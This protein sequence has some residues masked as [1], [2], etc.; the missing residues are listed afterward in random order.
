MFDALLADARA[1]AETAGTRSTARLL[2]DTD[3]LSGVETIEAART[4]IDA[5][6]AAMLAELETRGT[7]D[8][9]FGLRTAGWVSKQCGGPRGCRRP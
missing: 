9:R 7:T 3:L 4:L 2:G 1:V 5:A 6:E 8:A